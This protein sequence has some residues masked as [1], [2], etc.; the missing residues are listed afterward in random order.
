MQVV[1]RQSPLHALNVLCC[2]KLTVF[3]NRN[4]FF[5]LQKV[6]FEMHDWIV[7]IHLLL[8]HPSMKGDDAW[9]IAKWRLLRLR[10]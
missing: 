7:E 8:H 1:P 2:Q 5:E 9:R 10:E 3:Q 4:G 6:G